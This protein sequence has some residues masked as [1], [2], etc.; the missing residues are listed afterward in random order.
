VITQNRL[1]EMLSYSEDTGLFTWLV[2]R[3]GNVKAGDIA[4]S[5]NVDGSVS[6]GV[7]GHSYRA[8][9]LVW[10]YKYGLWPLI[11]LDHINRIPRDN[12]LLNLREATSAQNS[13]NTS[14]HRDNVTGFK[15]V[16]RNRDRFQARIMHNGKMLRLGTYDSAEEAYGVYLKKAT[17]L[18][19]DF[20]CGG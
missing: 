17:E 3:Q 1:K 10:L 7:D 16:T 20:A 12:R 11:E 14:V 8:H 4:G 2:S 18:F 6:I 19:G 13:M 9:R 15:G 5:Q